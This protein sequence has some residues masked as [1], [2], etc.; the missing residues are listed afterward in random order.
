MERQPL[1]ILQSCALESA[2]TPHNRWSGVYDVA[3]DY[4]RGKD[5]T[6]ICLTHRKGDKMEVVATYELRSHSTTQW[7]LILRTKFGDQTIGNVE[8]EGDMCKATTQHGS[9]ATWQ[10]M[11]R[12]I[13]Y[14][15]SPRGM[16]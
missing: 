1:P 14:L 8:K 11:D 10:N 7:L 16:T 4:S 6:V 5:S 12:A 3:I 13:A 15:I 2:Y 9:H